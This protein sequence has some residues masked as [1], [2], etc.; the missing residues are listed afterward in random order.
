V[1]LAIDAMENEERAESKSK[2]LH[3]NRQ[4]EAAIALYARS[5]SVK[6][7]TFH[8]LR[9]RI[10][11]Q[12]DINEFSALRKERANFE[13]VSTAFL[14]WVKDI[15]VAKR[16]RV[17]AQ[18]VERE[19]MIRKTFNTWRGCQIKRVRS[20]MI[21]FKTLTRRALEWVRT[22]RA[23]VRKKKRQ[24]VVRQRQK[25]T[26]LCFFVRLIFRSWKGLTVRN[27]PDPLRVTANTVCAVQF[28]KRR[29]LF[30]WAEIAAENSRRRSK[31]LHD[32][33]QRRRLPTLH[34]F[35]C[36]WLNIAHYTRRKCYI[37]C[38]LTLRK[39]SQHATRSQHVKRETQAIAMGFRAA[40]ARRFL[41]ILRSL[42]LR[43]IRLQSAMTTTYNK[44]MR[45]IF[46]RFWRHWRKVLKVY[47]HV[48]RN[49]GPSSVRDLGLSA[50][51]I[52]RDLVHTS[53]EWEKVL[54]PVDPELKF[55]DERNKNLNSSGDM[56]RTVGRLSVGES[57]KENVHINSSASVTRLDVLTKQ[58]LRSPLC[59]SSTDISANIIQRLEAMKE[60]EMRQR[61]LNYPHEEE[62]EDEGIVRMTAIFLR[63]RR[64]I[65]SLKRWVKRVVRR[66]HYRLCTD[67][68]HKI[69]CK[70]RMRSFITAATSLWIRSAL[71]RIGEMEEIQESAAKIHSS[72]PS[73]TG[74]P[75][76]GSKD[77]DRGSRMGSGGG[78]ERQMLSP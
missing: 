39:L 38:S 67:K 22:L 59:S 29:I 52:Q 35:L 23:I 31:I 55:H 78:S 32:L 51:T 25:G 8:A 2:I 47:L 70:R 44:I 3:E 64:L 34:Y 12:K 75:P 74:G 73:S 50:R 60:E 20:K 19:N 5:L 7:R 13:Y 21:V 27:R 6:R 15:E 56:G 58:P 43:N 37:A 76:D 77:K 65:C 48:P 24:A 45:R 11:R 41:H 68:I 10:I 14:M 61:D 33:Q 53:L 46:Y 4:E 17:L 30:A 66:S 72:Y 36:E 42:S 28:I 62:E 1:S 69:L 54:K 40:A 49:Q 18:W 63:K 16:G 9:T 57:E 26:A 71:K